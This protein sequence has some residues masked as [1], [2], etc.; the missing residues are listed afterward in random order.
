MA[1]FFGSL[2]TADKFNNFVPPPAIDR[3]DQQ[4]IGVRQSSQNLDFL[5]LFVMLKFF[6]ISTARTRDDGSSKGLIIVVTLHN[7]VLLGESE[8]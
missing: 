4:I 1:N 8:S 2:M 7:I 3:V 6:L 5:T